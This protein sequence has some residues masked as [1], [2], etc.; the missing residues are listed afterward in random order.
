MYP[1]HQ[2]ENIL[3]IRHFNRFYTRRFGLLQKRILGSAYTLLEARILYEIARNGVC[4][5]SD[6]T[7][8]LNIDAG[9][10]SR[11]LKKFEESALVNREQCSKDGRA[12]LLS[13]TEKGRIEQ[14]KLAE[15]AN[16]DVAEK[17]ARLGDKKLENLV[18][19]M[20]TI[21]TTLN[22]TA[23]PTTAIIRSHRPG[24]IGWIASS[25]AAFYAEEYGFNE[26]FEALVMRI[27]ADF[28]NDYN[29]TREHCWIAEADS[30]RV[31]SIM[32]VTESDDTAKLRLFYVDAEARGLGIGSQLVDECLSF[33]QKA[34]YKRVVLYTNACLDAARR[35]YER[36]GFHL[37]NEAVHDTFG[38]PQTEQDWLL[39][40]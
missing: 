22:E 14:A 4:N 3:A 16:E 2:I 26:N 20:K 8:A 32:L 31:G 28:I 9:Y 25:Q 19:A 21:E 10:L 1:D 39:E 18:V 15:I 34:G 30:R 13:L 6:V 7:A 12:F 17:I 38:D 23:A 40:F 33:A 27:C 29:P 35:I 11:I 5:A 37:I 36:A 24:D